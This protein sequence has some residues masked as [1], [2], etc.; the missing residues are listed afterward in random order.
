M[1]ALIS[2][3]TKVCDVI[4]TTIYRANSPIIYARVN[5]LDLIAYI[6]NPMLLVEF[7]L[8]TQPFKATHKNAKH[9]RQMLKNKT[10][11]KTQFPI[12]SRNFSPI[13]KNLE[14]Q[15]RESSSTAACI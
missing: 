12:N 5:E 2:N 14:D 9:E 1:V 15:Y 6:A 8:Y 4:K 3:T 11:H 10:K 7:P 13:G